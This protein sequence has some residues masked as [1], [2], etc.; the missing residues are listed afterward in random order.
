MH[1]NCARACMQDWWSS[2]FKQSVKDIGRCTR[3]IAHARAHLHRHAEVVLRQGSGV[4]A[5]LD[6]RGGVVRDEVEAHLVAASLPK[7]RRRV[8]PRP[9]IEHAMR[10]QAIAR[11]QLRVLRV[12]AALE[13]EIVPVWFE[14]SYKNSLHFCL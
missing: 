13:V 10:H 1:V 5:R 7:V 12:A 2:T 14:D 8:G 11:Q 9:R 4:D 6:R 3:L